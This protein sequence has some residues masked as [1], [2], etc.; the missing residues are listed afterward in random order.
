MCG[1][2]SRLKCGGARSTHTHECMSRAPLSARLCAHEVLWACRFLIYGRLFLSR[3]FS[4]MFLF[5]FGSHS[6][7]GILRHHPSQFKFGDGPIKTLARGKL[8][9]LPTSGCSSL[10]VASVPSVRRA[11]GRMRTTGI[12]SARSSKCQSFLSS[13]LLLAC[14]GAWRAGFRLSQNS[15]DTRPQE[16]SRPRRLRQTPTACAAGATHVAANAASGSR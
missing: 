5:N 6:G 1:H 2:V 16:A 10:V 11:R 3:S 9:A 8:C 4:T 7:F 14:F 15:L 13:F 12:P